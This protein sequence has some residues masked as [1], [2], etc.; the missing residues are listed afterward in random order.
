M[1]A[2]RRPRPVP[3]DLAGV[4]TYPLASRKSKVSL[5][6]FARERLARFKKKGGES[7]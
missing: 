4:R 2:K 1:K 5:R 6:D 7:A 3:L